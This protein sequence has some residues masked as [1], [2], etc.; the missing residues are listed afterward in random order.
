MRHF[1]EALASI[2]VTG[3]A[4]AGPNVV[5]TAFPKGMVQTIGG[6]AVSD[7]FTIAN[8]GDAEAAIN[9]QRNATFFTVSPASALLPPGASQTITLR[10]TTQSTQGILASSVS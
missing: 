5:V 8:V 7:S 10:G 6:N 1:A 3:V 2:V 9:L 4:I